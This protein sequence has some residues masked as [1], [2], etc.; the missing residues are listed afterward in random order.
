MGDPVVHFEV[1]GPRGEELAK[2]YCDL[3]GWKGPWIPEMDYA[4]VDTF[5]GDGINGGI[6]GSKDGSNGVVFYVAVPELQPVL[7]KAGRLGGK[8]VQEPTEI[9]NIVTFARFTDPEGNV[10]GLVRSAEPGV[11][12][13]GVSP[14]SNPSV[15]WFEVLGK[16]AAALQSFY[17]EVFG[18]T[19]KASAGLPT[20][21]EVEAGEGGIPGAVGA[22]PAGEPNV[23][24]YARVDDVQ[25]YLEKAETLGAKT[26]LEPVAVTPDTTIAAF[27]DPQENVFGLYRFTKS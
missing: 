10:I 25:R 23:T 8:T 7:D 4:L 15:S 16:D 17:K 13:P 14:G 19:I 6:G 22:V 18:W 1:S 21:G 3:F 2:F 5:G 9:P 27:K 24:V 12:N 11:D 20:Y 26:V